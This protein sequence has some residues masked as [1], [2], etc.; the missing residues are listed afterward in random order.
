MDQPWSR[1]LHVATASALGAG[2]ALTGAVAAT[3]A[4]QAATTTTAQ[5][6]A[7]EFRQVTL[8][9]GAAQTGEP[10]TLAVLPDGSVLH[11]SRGGT[12]YYTKDNQT[13]VAGQ[14]NVYT[15]DEE[16]LQGM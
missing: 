5:A 12:I 6:P 3:S 7:G 1:L 2:I 8:A 11:D 4:S 10:M 14:L 16:G 9:K 15:H 13:T